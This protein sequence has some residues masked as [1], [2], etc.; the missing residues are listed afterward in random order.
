MTI[1]EFFSNL[2]KFTLVI[3][4]IVLIYALCVAA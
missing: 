3:A 2:G 1:K 4:I